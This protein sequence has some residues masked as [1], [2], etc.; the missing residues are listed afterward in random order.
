M[1]HRVPQPQRMTNTEELTASGQTGN[2]AVW[3]LEPPQRDLD[4]NVITLQPGAE[5]G[6][7]EGPELDV[8]LYVYAGS[9]LLHGAEGT[10]Q[11]SVGDI[12]YLPAKARRAFVAGDQ[13]LSYFSVHQRKK[14][15]GLMPIRRNFEA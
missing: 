14:T 8:L 1:T 10:V 13:G 11:L 9:G 3:K 4:A 7:H 2:G 15:T 5:I 6:E 12:I